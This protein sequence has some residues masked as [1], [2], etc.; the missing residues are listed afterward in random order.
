MLSVGYPTPS[1]ISDDPY[2]PDAYKRAIYLPAPS[3]FT[4]TFLEPTK[5]GH[6][7]SYGMRISAA[8]R[9]TSD[10]MSTSTAHSLLEYDIWRRWEDCLWFQDSLEQEY[11]RLAREKKQR[12]LRG[13]GVK[14]NGFYLQDRASSFESLPPGP[15]P[16]SVAQD[17]HEYLPRL[18][19]KGTVFRA[20]QATINQRYAQIKAMVDALYHDDLPSL[21]QEIRASHVVTDFFGY[22]R[23]DFDLYENARKRESGSSARSII[24]SYFSSPH[25]SLSHHRDDSIQTSHEVSSVSSRSHVSAP[26]STPDMLR[27]R[28][29]PNKH[30]QNHSISSFFTRPGSRPRALSTT[31][32]DSSSCGSDRGSD[33]CTASNVPDIVEEVP[34]TFG[35]NPQSERLHAMLQA[36]P[37]DEEINPRPD[38]LALMT[39]L[40]VKRRR[41]IPATSLSMNPSPPLSPTLSELTSVPEQDQPDEELRP[42]RES[43]MTIDSAATYL[44]GLHLSLPPEHTQRTSVATFLTT[45]SAEA[46][47]QRRPLSRSLPPSPNRPSVPK[48]RLSQAITLS[49]FEMWPDVD[50]DECD[51]E[52]ASALGTGMRDSFPRPVSLCES[53]LDCTPDA[54]LVAGYRDTPTPIC[55]TE[56]IIQGYFPPSP[57]SS[58]ASGPFSVSGMSLASSSSSVVPQGMISIKATLD[59]AIVVLRI[60]KDASYEELRDR[61]HDKFAGQEGLSLSRSF[62]IALTYPIG[63]F[64]YRKSRSNAVS[65]AERMRF[66]SSQWDWDCVVASHDGGKLILRI[67]DIKGF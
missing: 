10:R 31:S 49:D 66:I 3:K 57:T 22:W 21:L 67:L 40:A 9:A 42:V 65:S 53:L 43:W 13:K 39:S 41:K 17:I 12:L 30:H 54:P 7:H 47:V 56:Y 27:S 16:D 34:I 18:T 64:A 63:Q 52:I 25:S 23:R 50:E 36:L 19:K 37:E 11:S 61:L 59:Q 58:T 60:A 32:S 20:S 15:H 51:S 44:D 46:V 35:H 48:S 4:I 2:A 28:Y 38:A 8:H 62:T 1:A 45:D 14:K 29:Y 24:S 26:V 55:S 5:Q 33:T 6:S